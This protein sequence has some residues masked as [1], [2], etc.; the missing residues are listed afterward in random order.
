[1]ENVT[2]N[3]EKDLYQQASDFVRNGQGHLMLNLLAD[4]LLTEQKPRTLYTLYLG[5]DTELNEA[6]K[7]EIAG[8]VSA[9]TDSF[10]MTGATGFFSNQP[11][12]TQLVQIA[13]ENNKVAYDCAEKLRSHFDQIAVG[14]VETGQYR[15]VIK[16]KP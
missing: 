16:N 7:Q 9:F 1:M 10:T 13:A 2:K 6:L 15:R 5:L 8:I 12:Y 11:E 14:V 3:S 4:L